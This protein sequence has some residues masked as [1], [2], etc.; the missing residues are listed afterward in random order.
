MEDDTWERTT[1]LHPGG[2]GAGTPACR[3]HL[4]PRARRTSFKDTLPLRLWKPDERS[5][6]A[7]SDRVAG[8]RKCP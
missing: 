8:I 2:G 3:G 7:A 4:D 5:G 6:G 1:H